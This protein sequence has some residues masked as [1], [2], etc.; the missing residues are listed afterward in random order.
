M[1]HLSVFTIFLFQ[2]V[3]INCSESALLDYTEADWPTQ[4]LGKRQTPINFPSS[5]DGNDTY[6]PVNNTRI[7]FNTYT[8]VTG[9]NMYQAIHDAKFAFKQSYMGDLFFQ[10]NGYF[11][12]YNLKE[13]HFHSPSEHTFNGTSYE[14]EMHLV[15]FK[16][17]S[18]FNYANGNFSVDPDAQ[19]QIL[20]VG[21]LFTKYDNKTN[22][23]S[24]VNNTF[25]QALKMWNP[26]AIVD[27]FTLNDFVRSDKFFL[28]YEGSLTTPACNETV[29]W[30]VMTQLERIS[31]TQLSDF[32]NLLKS[33]GYTIT[34]RQIKPLNGR[35]IYYNDYSTFSPI[36][37]KSNGS[38]ITNFLFISIF[39]YVLIF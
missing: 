35:K 37:L 31:T 8:L 33:K 29:N 3:I 17:T 36:V 21:I 10:K 27:N 38:F 24:N 18:F 14:M 12:K 30:V 26:L 1:I 7:L 2:L 32:S 13:I 34:N 6:L 5:T 9:I 19:Q 28:H 15:H 11:Y 16:D 39:L 20:V 4:C 23:N 25:I 22:L